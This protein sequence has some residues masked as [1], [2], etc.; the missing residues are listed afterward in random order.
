MNYC[1]DENLIPVRFVHQ[2]IAIYE[3][4]PNYI[5]AKL[6]NYSA[7]PWTILNITRYS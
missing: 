7:D 1:H 5:I 3:T 6:R 2:A 4:L